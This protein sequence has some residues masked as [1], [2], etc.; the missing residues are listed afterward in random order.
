MRNFGDIAK[1]RIDYFVELGRAEHS[2]TY[3]DEVSDEDA[4]AFE[5]EHPILDGMRENTR[6]VWDKLSDKDKI[7]IYR[8][9][10]YWYRY[11]KG[12]V[13]H[14]SS[15]CLDSVRLTARA[16]MAGQGRTGAQACTRTRHALPVT[17]P[18]I[19]SSDAHVTND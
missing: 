10:A 7:S 1:S 15:T 13:A 14:R 3:D 16:A 6:L 19:A 4:L 9:R 18:V 11:S 8:D 12:Y 5:K 2:I 17:P